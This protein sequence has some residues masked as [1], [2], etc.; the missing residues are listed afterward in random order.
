MDCCLTAMTPVLEDL[1][2]D[3]RLGVIANQQTAVLGSFSD[4]GVAHLFDVIV[5]SEIG[6]DYY[7]PD[8]AIFEYGLNQ[9]G[10]AASRGDLCRGPG[11]QRRQAGQGDGHEDDPFPSR[12]TL[13]IVYDPDDPAQTADITIYDVS[14]TGGCGAAPGD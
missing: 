12:G 1:R 2:R 9:A 5:I 13:W 8:P 3:F 6:R 14:E 7:K 4:Y 10:V 11:G